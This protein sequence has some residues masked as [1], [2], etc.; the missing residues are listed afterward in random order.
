MLVACIFVTATLLR[1][2]SRRLD[3]GAARQRTELIQLRRRAWTLGTD[4]AR[5]RASK[6]I[7]K[8]VQR[9]GLRVGA[10]FDRMM[11]PTFGLEPLAE[12]VR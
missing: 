2:E 7:R 3:A 10:E 4:L 8:R 1:A 5:L 6:H 12:G 11:F 9:M